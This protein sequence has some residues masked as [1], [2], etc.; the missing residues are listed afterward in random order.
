MEPKVDVFHIFLTVATLLVSLVAGF[1][2]AFACVVMPGTGSLGD[3]EF[4]RSF[5]VVDRVIQN[6][7]PLFGVVWLGSAAA[8][9]VA[10]VLGFGRL[11]GID[12]ALLVGAAILFLGGVQVPTATINVPLNNE[13]QRLDLGA[14]EES[15][16]LEA[17]AAFEPKWNLWNQIRT[18]VATLSALMLLVLI[19]KL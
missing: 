13:L 10:A 12:R 7:Q 17:R 8:L 2:F 4:L 14:L 11:E 6:G 5:Q 3:R 15:A 18:V 19:L 9:L 16:V 1:T